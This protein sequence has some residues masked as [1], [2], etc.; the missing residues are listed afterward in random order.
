MTLGLAN[1]KQAGP[2][3]PADAGGTA[4]WNITIPQWVQGSDFWFQGV[5]YHEATNVVATTAQ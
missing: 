3:L 1:P 4:Q 2:I 5:Q